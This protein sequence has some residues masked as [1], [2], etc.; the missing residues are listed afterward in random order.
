MVHRLFRAARLHEYCAVAA[1]LGYDGYLPVDQTL[2]AGSS[3]LDEKS[4]VVASRAK[5]SWLSR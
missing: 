1:R 4:S 3:V 5:Q 2:M